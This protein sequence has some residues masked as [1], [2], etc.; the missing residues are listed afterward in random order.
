MGV[1]SPLP[2]F[3]AFKGDKEM[4]K[5]ITI[6]VPY[7]EK[8]EEKIKFVD[9]KYVSYSIAQRYNDILKVITEGQ[10]LH[11]E[12][13]GLLRDI[14]AMVRV[15]LPLK[16]R[17]EKIKELNDKKEK[18]H[19][20]LLALEPRE[21]D[22][23]NKLIALTRDLLEANGNEDKELESEEFW[24]DKVEA[25]EIWKLLLAAISKDVGKGKSSKK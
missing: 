15:D 24:K 23:Y 2:S 13:K 22:T 19:A 17:R 5:E 6:E 3:M 12:E 10:R 9:I 18:I 4:R 1:L 25:E 11:K 16:Q 21:G 7:F 8:G 20:K 14:G